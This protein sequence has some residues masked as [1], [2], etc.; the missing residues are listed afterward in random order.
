[1]SLDLFDCPDV[2]MG[3]IEA[4]GRL[5]RDAAHIIAD[6]PAE[7]VWLPDNVTGEVAGP[8]L[9]EETLAPYYAEMAEILHAK[10]K[11]LVCHMDGMMRRLTDTVAATDLDI[12]EAF[13]PPPDADLPLD[14]ARAAWPGKAIWINYPS[15]VHLAEPERVRE[16]TRDLVRAAGGQPGFLVGI[17]ENIPADVGTRS[18]EAVAEV[19]REG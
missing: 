8:A 13:T 9:F 12:I 17:T 1:M 10:G 16:V 4:M 3:A 2:V 6:S 19:L 7:F 18:L 11:R 14:E 15:S 5:S